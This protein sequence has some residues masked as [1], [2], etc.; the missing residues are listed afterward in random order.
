[1]SSLRP[2]SETSAAPAGA[3]VV[4]LAGFDVRLRWQ[5]DRL[6]EALKPWINSFSPGAP[7]EAFDLFTFDFRVTRDDEATATSGTPER[8]PEDAPKPLVEYYY[9]SGFT[10]NGGFLF[11]ASDGSKLLASPGERHAEVRVPFRALSGPPWPLRDLFSAGLVTFLRSAGRFPIHAAAVDARGD[12]LL[13][14]GPPMTGKTALSLNFVRRGWSWVADDKV[15]LSWNDGGLEAGGFLRFSNID[16]SLATVFPEL[17]PLRGLPPAHPHSPKRAAALPSIY[18]ITPRPACRPRWLIFSELLDVGP[19]G[20][21][22]LD[23]KGAFLELL[24]HSP[25]VNDAKVTREQTRLLSRLAETAR[26]FRLHM[27]RDILEEEDRLEELGS[28]MDLP[29]GPVLD[30]FAGR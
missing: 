27:G 29:L 14:V 25:V 11:V 19:T 12:G 8:Y 28:L 13:I 30:A 9:V 3:A 18:G 15:L 2:P 6:M 7:G 1:V 16:P 17:S 21:T 26:S 24:R 22:P 5:D 20:F 23:R 4:R 10:V